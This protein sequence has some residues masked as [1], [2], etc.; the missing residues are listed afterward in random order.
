MNA[1][2]I[3]ERLLD[4]VPE[5]VLL[6]DE[7]GRYLYANQTASEFLDRP[8]EGIVGRTDEELFPERSAETIEKLHRRALEAG[9]P[10]REQYPLEMPSGETRY[11][12]S[13]LVPVDEEVAGF[14]AVAGIVRDVTERHRAERALARAKKQ[15]EAVF[16][17]NPVALIV[18]DVNS[19]R[20]HE[21]NRAWEEI[22]GYRSEE[23]EGEP[24]ADY[25]RELFLDPEFPARLRQRVAEEGEAR[26]EMTRVRGLDGK[27]R[28]VLI[29]A[30]PVIVEEEVFVVGAA[31]D[32]SP[33]REIER[34]LRRRAL[35]DPLTGLPNRDLFR[36]R[37]EQ[38]VR[39]SE[40]RRESFALVY[41]DLDGFKPVNDSF[42]HRTGDEVLVE[43]AERLESRV[44]D[45]D[46]VARVG[47]DEF[48]LL[49][50]S[51]DGEEGARMAAERL[52]EAFGEPFNVAAG[53]VR[54][55]ASVGAVVVPADVIRQ[56]TDEENEEVVTVLVAE[57]D[58]A[59]YAVKERGGGGIELRRATADASI[60]ASSH[61]T[62]DP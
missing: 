3:L 27:V 36:D 18:I 1:S 28:D 34:D 55:S 51:V 60:I 35:H 56:G 15:Y 5:V 48:L 42:G 53:N 32:I 39:R 57:A 25:E 46:T 31:Q 20:I 2:S 47:G 45:E 22:Y 4:L 38:A 14:R 61:A 29:S 33:L 58:R 40:R 6:Y 30:V 17:V 41:L 26:G 7:E 8:V 24:V 12:E 50:E 19:G 62:P 43:V 16:D 11:W 44:R 59:M 52:H 10:Q 49:L 21:V 23:V 37:C 54:L 13:T 9:E